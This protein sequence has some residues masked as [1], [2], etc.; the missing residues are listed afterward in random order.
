MKVLAIVDYSFLY[1]KYLF[2]VMNG[3]MRKLTTCLDWKGTM[4]EKDVSIIYY[5][6]KEIEGIRKQ[7]E[8]LGHDLT[9]AICFDMPCKERKQM[10]DAKSSSDGTA[11]AAKAYKSKRVKR[12]TEEDIENIEF[13]ERTLNSAGHNT[14]R[15]EGLEADDI[16]TS[17]VEKYKEEYDVVV[18]YTSDKDLLVNV[19][20]TVG[21][22]RYKVTKGYGQVDN[23]N[24]TEYLEPEFKCSIPYNA[25]LLF[26]CTVGDKSDDVAGIKKFGPK[27]FDRMIDYLYQKNG[28]NLDWSKTNTKEGVAEILK[29]CR[30]YLTDEQLEQAFSSLDM[31]APIKVADEFISNLDRKPSKELREQTYTKYNM[32]SL[33]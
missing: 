20:S 19:D 24:F 11:E 32:K 8:D 25:L 5:S 6:M 18:I 10:A 27:A 12:L 29:K 21:V 13:V 30:G 16:I 17:L 22:M 7:L 2:Q 14:F 15:V 23:R 33:I 9:T 4:I 31:V 26:L 1:Y 3:K 28:G